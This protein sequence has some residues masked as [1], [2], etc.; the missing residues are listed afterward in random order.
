MFVPPTTPWL[1]RTK[2]QPEAAWRLSGCGVGGPE[3]GLETGACPDE[4]KGRVVLL[5]VPTKSTGCGGLLY[6]DSCVCGVGWPQHGKITAG[7]HPSWPP[8]S[9][10]QLPCLPR[11]VPRVLLWLVGPGPRELRS[12]KDLGES[13]NRSGRS[14]KAK[15]K[16]EQTWYP[17]GQSRL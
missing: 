12:L 5:R 3:P 1:K 16:A 6:G 9:K 8:K 2:S 7:P 11:G 4:E 14:I 10:V 13:K 17:H 15:H